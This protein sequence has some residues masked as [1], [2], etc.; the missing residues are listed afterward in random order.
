MKINLKQ[1]FSFPT[2]L[3]SFIVIMSISGCDKFIEK[4]KNIDPEHQQSKCVLLLQRWNPYATNVFD[5]TKQDNRQDAAEL[6]AEMVLICNQDLL[7]TVY[8]NAEVKELASKPE[9]IEK[10]KKKLELQK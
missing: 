6:Y 10:A 1:Y 5:Q 8:P 9:T 7:K 2:F 4:V 3:I